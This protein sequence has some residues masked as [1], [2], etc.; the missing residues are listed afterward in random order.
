MLILPCIC[1]PFMLD[2]EQTQNKGQMHLCQTTC[3][4]T[5]FGTLSNN[6][7]IL[8]MGIF[9]QL[10]N[11]IFRCLVMSCCRNSGINQ[12]AHVNLHFCCSENLLFFH[13]I[14]RS[15]NRQESLSRKQ[16]FSEHPLEKI[17]LR[18]DL[19]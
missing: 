11:L 7:P 12:T 9:F 13:Q 2:F 14:S 6:F 5:R 16:V 15:K 19:P 8:S 3:P 17:G 18:Q 4:I 10:S 1:I